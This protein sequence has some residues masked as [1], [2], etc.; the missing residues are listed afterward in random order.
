MDEAAAMARGAQIHLLLE[1]L[2][3]AGTDGAGAILAAAGLPAGDALPALL[4]EAQAVLAAHPAL[5]ARDTLAEVALTADLPDP[6]LRL[7]GAVD[8]LVVAPDRVL[9]VDFKTNATVPD[10]AEDVPDGLL[11]QM[12]AYAAALARIYP[13]RGIETAILWTRTATLMP[14]PPGLTAR[15]LAAARP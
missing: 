15:A 11:R 5:F 9:A 12:G 2:P 14:L 1:H 10:R 6:G 13:D 7:H 3:A 8:R 4:S